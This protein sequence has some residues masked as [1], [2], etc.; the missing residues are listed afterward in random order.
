MVGTYGGVP[1]VLDEKTTSAFTMGWADSWDLRGQFMGYLWALREGGIHASHAVVRGIA[2][3]K[4]QFDTRSAF[5]MF[6]D[7]LLH[8]WEE[9]ML[10]DVQAICDSYSALRA[11]TDIDQ[12]YPYDFADACGSYGGCA[13][14]PLCI[15][16]NPHDFTSNYI[17]HIW[18]P[19]SPQ[20]IE[21]KPK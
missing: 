20:P 17:H 2:I 13:F 16:A 10:K 1:V 8:R 9:Q 3:Q 7:H 5:V 4:T 15:A 18:N 11:G 21:E 12:L 6:P 19:L 14:A